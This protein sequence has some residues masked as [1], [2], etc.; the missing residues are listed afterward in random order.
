MA[1][2]LLFLSL[3]KHKDNLTTS[4]LYYTLLI[5]IMKFYNIADSKIDVIYHGNSL[6]YNDEIKLSNNLNFPENYLL[7]V[8][9]RDIYK[10]FYFFYRIYFKLYDK[11]KYFSYM[12]WKKI[13]KK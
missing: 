8:G 12:H 3:L 5:L 13:Y 9:S 6:Y 10:N 2:Y 7:Y 4:T 1:L 11:R